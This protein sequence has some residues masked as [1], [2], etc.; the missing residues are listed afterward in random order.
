VSRNIRQSRSFV[1]RFGVQLANGSLARSFAAFQ[2]YFH[3]R[4]RERRRAESM[5]SKHEFRIPPRG[6]RR[7]CTLIKARSLPYL[8]PAHRLNISEFLFI[9]V[10]SLY[11]AKHK[12]SSREAFGKYR[13]LCRS[14][15]T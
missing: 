12:S 4:K 6:F 7:I 11:M 10:T 3:Q 2:I 1:D 9:P 14:Y 8:T 15:I 13:P 5:P